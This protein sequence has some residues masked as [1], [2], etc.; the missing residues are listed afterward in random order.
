MD[1]FSLLIFPFNHF[2]LKWP[3]TSDGNARNPTLSSKLSVRHPCSKSQ[4]VVRGYRRKPILGTRTA[5]SKIVCQGFEKLTF[6]Q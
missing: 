4:L 2:C 3:S 5:T 1:T 6:I